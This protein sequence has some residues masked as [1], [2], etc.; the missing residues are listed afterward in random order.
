MQPDT[1]HHE[2]TL[3]NLLTKETLQS[4][5]RLHSVTRRA[6]LHEK[7]ITRLVQDAR[8]LHIAQTVLK[9][10]IVPRDLPRLGLRAELALQGNRADDVG[11]EEDC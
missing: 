3:T 2:L 10:A 11:K 9:D 1:Q 7:A 8:P 4:Q 5:S 6:E